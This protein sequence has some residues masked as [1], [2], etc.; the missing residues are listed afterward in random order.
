MFQGAN[1]PGCSWQGGKVPKRQGAKA[2]R[3][4]VCQGAEV[5]GFQGL[6]FQGTVEVM[7]SVRVRLRPIVQLVLMTTLALGCAPREPQAR[8]FEM[9]G[10]ILAIRSESEVLVKHEDIKGFMPAMTMPYKVRD[11]ELLRG[12]VAGDL[13]TGTLAVSDTDAWLTRLEK[14]GTAPIP[15]DVP[16]PSP[17]AQVAL[18]R[19][20]DTPPDTT[21]TDEA[22]GA[23][24]LAGWRG[25]AAAITFIYTRCP[26]P[27]YCPLMDRRFADVQRTV[28][29]DGTL[30]G[31]AHLLSVSFDPDAD[32]PDVLRAH[33]M[34]LG[35]DPAIWHFATAP[36][37]V[38]DAFAAAFGVNVI[39]E[40]DATITHNLRTAVIDAQGRVLSVYDGT[41][42]TPDHIV[43]DL[44]EALAP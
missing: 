2:P 7:A 41:A 35:A 23:L 28:K 22:G 30:S 21:L 14:I 13:V 12:K 27:Q 10:Q 8:R 9:R 25:S 3:C 32:T 36:R 38:V 15:D 6:V 42:W 16:T 5:P 18:L 34:K 37:D 31:R 19:P 26:L 17:A 39:R 4:Q 40:A 24:S 44:R 33:A 29:S 1:V 43:A 20:G 11:P